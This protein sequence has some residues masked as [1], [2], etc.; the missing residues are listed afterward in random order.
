MTGLPFLVAQLF[1][2]GLGLTAFICGHPSLGVYFQGV[3]G[4]V[5][6]GLLVHFYG[7][8]LENGQK[9]TDEL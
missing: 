9:G 4:G 3:N 5:W 7:K 1:C 2:L 6:I 8:R